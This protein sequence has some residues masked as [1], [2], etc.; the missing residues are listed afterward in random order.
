MASEVKEE[1]F[2]GNC[3]SHNPYEYPARM[4]CLK[5]YAKNKHPVVDTLWCCG[6]WS[7]VVQACYCVHDAIKEKNGE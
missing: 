2:C 3:S 5:R 1:R 4:F 6:D 7:P